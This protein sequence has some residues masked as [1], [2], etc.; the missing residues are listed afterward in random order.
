ML[1]KASTTQSFL[2]VCCY[3]DSVLPIYMAS[4]CVF[5]FNST[6]FC[7]W[8]KTK[9]MEPR[10]L[11]FAIQGMAF[12]FKNFTLLTHLDISSYNALA[13]LCPLSNKH[14]YDHHCRSDYEHAYIQDG[15]SSAELVPTGH[16]N[17]QNTFLYLFWIGWVREK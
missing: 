11:G 2:F 5:L 1:F 14:L 15:T 4:W 3:N 9:S 6:F 7:S 12:K 8:N 16:Y 17:K 10:V 13:L